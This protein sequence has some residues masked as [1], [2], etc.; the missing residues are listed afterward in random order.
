VSL[1]TW[2]KHHRF[3]REFIERLIVPQ[4]SAVWSAAP[5]QM[6]SFAARFLAEFFDNHGML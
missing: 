4:V 2:L 6:W 5:R 1:R 3:S